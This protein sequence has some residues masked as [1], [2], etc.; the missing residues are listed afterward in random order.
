M[1][2]F[3][4]IYKKKEN[5]TF[6]G[7]EERSGVSNSPGAM[8]LTLIPWAARSRARGRVIPDIEL[9]NEMC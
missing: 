8:V 6:S 2:K 5:K 3:L 9:I 1:Q 4:K 7:R